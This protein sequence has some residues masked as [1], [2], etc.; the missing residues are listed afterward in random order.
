MYEF[1]KNLNF[2]GENWQNYFGTTNKKIIF[3]ETL[4]IS[5]NPSVGECLDAIL[6]HLAGWSEL[7][8]VRAII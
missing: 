7:A 3:T 8:R 2:F 4:K 6:A 5:V 1:M